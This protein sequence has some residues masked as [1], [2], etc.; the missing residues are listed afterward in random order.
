MV[1]GHGLVY[2]EGDRVEGYSNFLYIL[3]IAP[4]FLFTEG[5]GI[6]FWSTAVNYLFACLALLIWHRLARARFGPTVAAF[7]AFLLALCPPLWAAISTGLETPL[8]LLLTVAVW[9]VL[10]SVVQRRGNKYLAALC[11]LLVISLLSRADGIIL[12]FMVG[13]FLLCRKRMRE[14]GFVIAVVAAAAAIY[15]SWR[16]HYYG[17][18]LPNTYYVRISGPLLERITYAAKQLTHIALDATLLPYIVGFA[19]SFGCVARNITRT[20]IT[21]IQQIPFEVIYIGSMISYWFYVGGD[22]LGDRFLLPFFPM[23]LVL[24][25]TLLS[26]DATFRS[27]TFIVAL[28]ICLHLAPLVSDYRFQFTSSKHDMWV[29]LGEYLGEWE[30]GRTIAVGAAGKIPFFSGLKSLDMFGLN[31]PVIAR[32]STDFF[33]PGHNKYDADYVL[34][35]KPDLIASFIDPADLDL[36]NGLWRSK[37][38]KAGYEIRYLVSGIVDLGFANVVDVHGKSR[39]DIKQFVDDGFFY[40]VLS[41]T[42]SL[43]PAQATSPSSGS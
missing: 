31:E 40:A 5:L 29:T 11:A 23:G 24:V 26:G 22:Q 17:A 3:I 41:R 2:N 13:L 1:E 27:R 4:A 20:G 9:S 32:M 30:S 42:D 21:S 15:T 14:L 35:R 25:L 43:E 18:F 19:V 16:Y 12:S 38:E 33:V 6:Y 7:G 10:P 34:S 28:L 39:A 36:H 37:Y 8:I